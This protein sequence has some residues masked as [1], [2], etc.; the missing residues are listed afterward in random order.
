MAEEIPAARAT[1]GGRWRRGGPRSRG[2]PPGPRSGAG[3]AGRPGS[4]RGSTGE[5]GEARREADD[6]NLQSEPRQALAARR[7]APRPVSCATS[8]RSGPSK[9]TGTSTTFGRWRDGRPLTEPRRSAR[10]A[11]STSSGSNTTSTESKPPTTSITPSMAGSPDRLGERRRGGRRAARE[12]DCGVAEPAELARPTPI[13]ASRRGRTAPTPTPARLQRGPDRPRDVG[14]SRRV[15]MHAQRAR[16][17]GGSSYP[18]TVVD[19]VVERKPHG[20]AAASV[21]S[22]QRARRCDRARRASRRAHSGDRRTPPRRPAAR[23]TP[24][25]RPRRARPARRATGPSARSRVA[26]ATASAHVL[27]DGHPVVEGAVGLH[28]ADPAALGAGDAVERGDLVED[29]GPDAARAR[30]PWDADRTPRG[31]DRRGARRSRRRG[32]PP[33][34]PSRA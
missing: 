5:I 2:S 25:P 8:S 3:A 26:S 27:V 11:G 28:G 12:H 14:R 4:A 7:R 32:G 24:Q 29:V 34:A 1:P 10:L 17:R 9:R 19:L 20:A 15:A 6:G 22:C 21:G 30:G 16:E 31:R 18:S 33:R 23:R 13:G